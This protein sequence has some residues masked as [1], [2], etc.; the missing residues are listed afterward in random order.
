MKNLL[1]FL[2][3]L[4]LFCFSQQSPVF[5]ID[6]LPPQSILIDKG[7]KWHTGDN[8]DFANFAFDDSK[9]ESLGLSLAYDIVTKGHGGEIEC[10]S[11][12]GEGTTFV[13]KLPIQNS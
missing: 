13:V 3:L 6:S 8:P 1:L 5:H 10:E 7:W 12:E 4:P 9:W 11:V 2:F